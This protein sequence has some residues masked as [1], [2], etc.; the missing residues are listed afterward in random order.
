VKADSGTS[1]VS[2]RDTSIVY[3]C[4]PS[5]ARPHKGAPKATQR[6]KASWLSEQLAAGI[7]T[8]DAVAATLA[9]EPEQVQPIANG[10]IAI[11]NSSWDKLG[12]LVANHQRRK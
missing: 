6:V 7:I 5:A 10:K 4:Y 8:A 12:A 11:A 1:S 9:I 3:H 2:H